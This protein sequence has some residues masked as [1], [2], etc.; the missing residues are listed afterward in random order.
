MGNAHNIQGAGDSVVVVHSASE[1]HVTAIASTGDHDSR[2]VE[3]LGVG[4]PIKQSADILHRIEPFQPVVH[5][6]KRL[7]VSYTATHVGKQDGAT[8]FIQEIIV[9]TQKR[10]ARLTFRAT[11]DVDDD[12]PFTSESR[13]GLIQEPTDHF[14]IERFPFDQLCRWQLARHQPA[15]FAFCPSCQLK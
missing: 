7:T 3:I 11:V 15:H 13:C 9:P 14:A 4:N 10:R 8:Q 6:H 2:C 5:G 12:G 1:G